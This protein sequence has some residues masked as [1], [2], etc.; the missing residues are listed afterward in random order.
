MVLRCIVPLKNT[1]GVCMSQNTLTGTTSWFIDPLTQGWTPLFP[2]PESTY[3]YDV[4]PS[5]ATK[6]CL[7]RNN[8]E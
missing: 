6:C 1:L 5:L 3:A 8:L 2:N 7:L 4:V